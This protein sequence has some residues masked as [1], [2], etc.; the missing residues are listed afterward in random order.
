MNLNKKKIEFLPQMMKN[1]LYNFSRA[2]DEKIGVNKVS[3]NPAEKQ[4]I[5]VLKNVNK[6]KVA[7]VI[8]NGPSVRLSDIEKLS[9][10]ITF[11]A[12]RFYLTYDSTDFRPSYY[13]VS[14][15]QMIEDFGAEIIKKSSSKNFIVSIFR[16]KLSGEYYWL[17]MTPT[18][19]FMFS[20]DISQNLSSGGAV[21]VAGIQIAYYMGIRKIVLYGIDHNFEFSLLKNNTSHYN[22]AVGDNNHFIPNYRSGTS[23]CPPDMGL[24]ENSIKNCDKFL[25][26]KGGWLKNGTRGGKLEVCE[27]IDIDKFL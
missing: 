2:L 16:P 19:P 12:N 5:S 9:Q 8:G 22:Q 21:I 6:G 13:L 1:R 15:P 10:E 18:A 3:L 4:E 14:D 26:T 24:I 23:W 20:T 11:C 7:Y 17:P 25:R 27:R